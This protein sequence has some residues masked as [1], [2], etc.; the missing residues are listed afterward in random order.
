MALQMS[1]R[2]SYGS[3][4]TFFDRYGARASGQAG[5]PGGGGRS[6]TTAPPAPPMA[7]GPRPPIL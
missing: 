7:S 6:E 2:G 1:A 5:D 4:L 3:A